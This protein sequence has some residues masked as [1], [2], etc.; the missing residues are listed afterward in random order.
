MDADYS[1]YVKTIE[2]YARPF[3]AFNIL[4]I[5]RVKT[6]D[7]YLP[8]LVVS[9]VWGNYWKSIVVLACKNSCIQGANISKLLFSEVQVFKL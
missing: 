5:G 3:L 8:I 6:S 1:F 9:H 7:L 2:M 4:A